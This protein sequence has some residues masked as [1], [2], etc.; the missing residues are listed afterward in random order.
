MEPVIKAQRERERRQANNA[1]ERYPPI[2][3]IPHILICV[4]DMCVCSN[5]KLSVIVPIITNII[6]PLIVFLSRI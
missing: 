1:R 4:R 6:I 5:N 3:Y 2:H